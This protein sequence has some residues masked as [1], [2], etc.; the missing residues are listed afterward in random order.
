MAGSHTVPLKDGFTHLR[1]EVHHLCHQLKAEELNRVYLDFPSA[2]SSAVSTVLSEVMSK[3][4]Y[5]HRELNSPFL[6]HLLHTSDYIL[7][8]LMSLASRTETENTSDS[9]LARTQIGT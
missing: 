2:R 9:K 8:C 7:S 1:L 3:S 5:C 6:G 4:S